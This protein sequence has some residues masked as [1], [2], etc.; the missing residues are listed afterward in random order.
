LP[1]IFLSYR[2]QDNDHALSVYVW[3]I[4]KYGRQTVFW[5][6][7]DI[8]PGL[9]FAERIETGLDS[10]AAFLTLIGKD[11]AE[12]QDEAGRRRLQQPDD[13]VR[14]ETSAAMK[15]GILVLPL[16]GSGATM[17]QQEDLPPDLEHLSGIQALSMTDMRFPALLE[18]KLSAAG[19]HPLSSP[20]PELSAAVVATRAGNLLRRQASRLM[21]RAKELMGQ[22][23]PDRA[24]EE[25]NEGTELMMALLDIVPGE[26]ELDLQLGYMYAAMGRYFEDARDR[27]RSDRYLDLAAAIF[28]RVKDEVERDDEASDEL[29]SVIK[30]LGEIYYNRGELEPAIHYYRAALDLVPEYSYAWHDL[31][32]ALYEKARRGSIDLE[33]LRQAL[34]MTKQTSLSSAGR[35]PGL[36]EDHL[37]QMDRWLQE[38]EEWARAKP[39]LDIRAEERASEAI[40]ATPGNAEAYLLRARARSAK[41]NFEG[42]LEDYDA[43]LGCGSMPAQ[44]WLERAYLYFSLNRYR[45]AEG[46]FTAFIGEGEPT[47]DAFYYRGRA[48]VEL[49]D[50][51]GAESDFTAAVERGSN[52]A[53]LYRGMVRWG[54]KEL[55]A[56]DADLSKSID[57]RES[58]GDAYLTRAQL[59]ESRGDSAG[60]LSD[61]QAAIENGHDTPDVLSRAGSALI[62]TGEAKQAIDKL[63]QAIQKGAE[64][65]K[66]YFARGFALAATGDTKAAAPDIEEAIRRGMDNPFVYYY[67]GKMRVQNGDA[68][69]A[70]ESLT[71]A[72]EAGY[73]EADAWD[74]RG[75]ARL[76]LENIAGAEQDFGEAIGR[77][78]SDGETYFNRAHTRLMSSNF[79]GAW[80]DLTQAI[81]QGYDKGGYAVRALLSAMTADW[82]Q[83]Y[84]D[85][86]E[87]LNRGMSHAKIYELRARA[88]SRLNLLEEAERSAAEAAT[89]P[90][91]ASIYG[92]DLQL[93]KGEFAEAATTYRSVIAIADDTA[94]RFALGLALLLGGDNEGARAEY[95]DAV[96]QASL[97]EIE[98]ARKELLYWTEGKPEIAAPILALLQGEEAAAAPA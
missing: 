3:L 39:H 46:D 51:R 40:R 33:A 69:A 62:A 48:R 73:Q 93:A 44:A 66:T 85:A 21:I 78:A 34:E 20:A 88:A 84:A 75:R 54:L 25:L 98:F 9:D 58:L 72:I 45:E 1:Q 14:R 5:D 28:Q 70:D 91:K 65:G 36:G 27:T 42:A 29:A 24:I 4:K 49:Q 7:K 87:A 38:C 60:A 53:Y 32:G 76:A 71:T 59:R 80:E 52:A 13:W 82:G 2:R 22:N 81:E 30:G 74:W 94:A 26:R 79:T 64:E 43:A 35:H 11:W 55:D 19:I 6:R 89:D 61:Y 68:A 83:C 95:S 37:A 86:N 23:Q 77:G 57:I 41:R 97:S 47:A 50:A 90:G 18:E 10:A 17:P 15:R 92:G 67:L 63:S 16:L 56:A 12:I 8:E 96:V 31:F